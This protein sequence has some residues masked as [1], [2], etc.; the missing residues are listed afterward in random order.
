MDELLAASKARYVSPDDIAIVYAGLDDKN[1]KFEWLNRAYEER[2]GF[3]LF[4]KQDPRLKPLRAET[5]FRDLLHRLGYS[6]ETA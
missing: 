4:V 2:A 6:S 3:L 1:R 5:R